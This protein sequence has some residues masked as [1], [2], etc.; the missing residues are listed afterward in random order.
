MNS[1][2]VGLLSSVQQSSMCVTVY[3]CDRESECVSVCVCV[4]VKQIIY[5]TQGLAWEA[6]ATSNNIFIILYKDY[7]RARG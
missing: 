4:C 5:T 6:Y 2:F 1:V 3:V 7:L